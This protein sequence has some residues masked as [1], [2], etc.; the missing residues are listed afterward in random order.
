MLVKLNPGVKFT[1]ILRAAFMHSDP[2]SAKKTDSLTYFALLGSE[3]VK[4]APKMFVKLIP[5]VKSVKRY[6][7]IQFQT[8]L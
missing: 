6:L 7:E 8:K 2:K 5:V 3:R 1:N 4:A